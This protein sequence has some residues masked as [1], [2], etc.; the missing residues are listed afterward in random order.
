MARTSHSSPGGLLAL[1]V[2]FIFQTSIAFHDAHASVRCIGQS[3]A[4]DH[5]QR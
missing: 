5:D 2:E 1:W 4:Q 3:A